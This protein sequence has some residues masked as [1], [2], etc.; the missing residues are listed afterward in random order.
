V[1]SGAGHDIFVFKKKE[2]LI[3]DGKYDLNLEFLE[4][5]K[6]D[7]VIQEFVTQHP[8]FSQFNPSSN[9][10][11][12]VFIYRSIRDDAVNILHSTLW[13]GAKG[14]FLD[15]DHWGGFGLSIN[16]QNKIDKLAID[17]YGNKHEHIN[18]IKLDSLN[19]I[20]GMEQIRKLGKKM[21]SNIYYGRIL[22]V[23]FTVNSN[24]QPLMLEVNCRGNAI[25]QYQMHNGGLFKEFTKE[26]LDYCNNNPK[27]YVIRI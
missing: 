12:K 5:Y 24:G 14:H 27:R 22:A 10:T 7:F 11:I 1:D 18:N 16:K 19:E 6:K 13:V 20:P 8:F 21:A 17:A 9:N 4:K 15:H 26:I 23:D 3:N 2:M 25:H